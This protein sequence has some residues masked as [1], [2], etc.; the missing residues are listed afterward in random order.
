[1]GLAICDDLFVRCDAEI[2]QLADQFL[3]GPETEVAI[4]VHRGGPFEVYCPGNMPAPGSESTAA[5]VFIGR[6]SIDQH[7]IRVVEPAQ[8][9]LGI[10]DGS[11]GGFRDELGDGWSDGAV[12]HGKTFVRP[13]M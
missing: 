4:P 2:V 12:L 3:S 1:M 10:R 11:R 5:L 8:Y 6:A 7:R 9:V 13:G